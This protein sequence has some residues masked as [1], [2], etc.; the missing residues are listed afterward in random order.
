MK[1][2]TRAYGI[3]DGNIVGWYA[4][5][6]TIRGFIATIPEPAVLALTGTS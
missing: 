1:S 4:T 3:D 2:D 5:E 6:N